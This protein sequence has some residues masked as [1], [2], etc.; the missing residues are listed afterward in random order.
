[1]QQKYVYVAACV[2]GMFCLLLLPAARSYSV[3][4]HARASTSMDSSYWQNEIQKVGAA[5]AY[6]EF[7]KTYSTTPL[8]FAHAYAHQFGALLYKQI[9]LAGI[10]VCDETFTFG[11]YHGM[12]SRAIADKGQAIIPDMFQTCRQSFGVSDAGCEHGIGHGIM[13]FLGRKNLETGVRACE[14]SQQSS[15]PDGCLGGL[16]MEYNSTA[17][18]GTSTTHL[19]VRVFD[20]AHPFEPCDSMGDAEARYSCFFEA[21]QW[22]KDATGS[23]SSRIGNLC[24]ATPTDADK[25]ACEGGW[26]TIVAE[27]E[28]YDS[29]RIREAC[30]LITSRPDAQRCTFGAIGRLMSAGY[31]NA[32]KTLCNQ[33]SGTLYGACTSL[34]A[35]S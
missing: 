14:T 16:F 33:L 10:A 5:V 29:N 17:I 9:G 19:D 3:A 23:D 15:V 4:Q 24:A 31:I 25:D 28:R 7:K 1:M 27:D 8:P 2:A 18:V 6:S 26:G 20:S 11:C 35:H 21:P 22:W 13:D 12:F 30:E 34:V 32:A